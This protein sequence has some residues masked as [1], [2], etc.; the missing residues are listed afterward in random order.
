MFKDKREMAIAL[1]TSDD[2][3]IDND[4][5]I[6]ECR[7]EGMG[8]T[9]FKV[10]RNGHWEDIDSFW[11]KFAQMKKIPN[12]PTLEVDTKVF[13]KEIKGNNWLPRH[14]MKW[15]VDMVCFANGDS[16]F[17]ETS[18]EGTT[19]KFWKIADGEQEGKTNL[20]GE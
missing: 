14:F 18:K 3:C 12:T 9:P 17:T 8:N 4:G 15:D 20:I 11:D 16:S 6:Y 7:D 10:Y 19:W 2:G 13:V 1:A 5:N